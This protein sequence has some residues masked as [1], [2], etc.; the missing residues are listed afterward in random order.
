M[1]RSSSNA[2]TAWYDIVGL[3]EKT[4][5]SCEGI[6][7]SIALIKDIIETEHNL[8]I[9]YNRIVLAGFSQGGALSLIVGLQLPTEM[10]VCN[11]LIICS[12]SWIDFTHV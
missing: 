10:K 3:T 7:E 12:I 9:A 4:A 1:Q 11:K 6:E 8:G 5:E 2:R